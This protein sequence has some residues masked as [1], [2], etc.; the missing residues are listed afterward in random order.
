M[1]ARGCSRR[2]EKAINRVPA[3]LQKVKKSS[4]S[5]EHARDF[6]CNQWGNEGAIAM[7]A[8]VVVVVVRQA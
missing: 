6:T 8:M 4:S 7:V 3:A 5:S 2:S 1:E